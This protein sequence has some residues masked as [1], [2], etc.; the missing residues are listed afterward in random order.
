MRRKKHEY[1]DEEMWEKINHVTPIQQSQEA[2]FKY[3]VHNDNQ[4]A[5]LVMTHPQA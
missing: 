5:S 2:I 3:M 4:T 1:I